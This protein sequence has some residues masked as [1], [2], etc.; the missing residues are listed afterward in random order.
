M[1]CG[2]GRCDPLSILRLWRVRTCRLYVREHRSIE[3]CMMR[4]VADSVGELD[5]IH[6]AP[7]LSLLLVSIMS[8]GR[9]LG[10]RSR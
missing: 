8:Y 5:E 6:G 10:R 4:Q 3:L 2:K 1:R 7:P 9:E